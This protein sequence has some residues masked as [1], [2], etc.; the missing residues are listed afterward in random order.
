[1]QS[2]A[3]QAGVQKL[4][5]A[6]ITHEV[7]RAVPS[8]GVAAQLQARDQRQKS[9]LPDRRLVVKVPQV[10]LCISACREANQ[11]TEATARLEKAH[12]L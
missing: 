1:M 8:S 2:G 7:G 3:H 12:T 4:I 5:E 11:Q 9:P 6:A 10:W